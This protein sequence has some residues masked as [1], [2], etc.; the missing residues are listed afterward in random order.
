MP[1]GRSLR[2]RRVAA[3]GANV[4]AGVKEVS[5]AALGWRCPQCAMIWSPAIPACS[6]CATTPLSHAESRPASEP[7]VRSHEREAGALDATEFNSPA[8]NG[9]DPVVQALQR[10][11]AADGAFHAAVAAVEGLPCRCNDGRDYCDGQT[12]AIEAIES[13]AAA[14][15]AAAQ[16]AI[17]GILDGLRESM[18]RT[19]FPDPAPDGPPVKLS[20]APGGSL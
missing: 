16:V 8:P 1:R 4:S 10:T 6:R 17:A 2:L 18:T 12:D 15:M 14:Y 3:R 9:V 20:N 5:Q 11:D 13:A 19:Q 7:G